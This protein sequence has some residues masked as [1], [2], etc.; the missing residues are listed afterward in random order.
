MKK[1]VIHVI[2]SQILQFTLSNL[3]STS[4]ASSNGQIRCEPLETREFECCALEEVDTRHS[5]HEED[6]DYMVVNRIPNL[7]SGFKRNG[8]VVSCGEVFE[9]AD[10]ITISVQGMCC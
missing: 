4:A 1:I 5:G 2:L 6:S 9:E 3:E 10:N 8:E 7:N